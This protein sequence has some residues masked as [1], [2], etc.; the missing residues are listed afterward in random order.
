MHS[1]HVRVCHSLLTYGYREGNAAPALVQHCPGPPGN[2][3]TKG[4][5]VRNGLGIRNLP[6]HIFSAFPL[7]T[8]QLDADSLPY[9]QYGSVRIHTHTHTTHESVTF[10]RKKQSKADSHSLRET[11]S[12][13]ETYGHSLNETACQKRPVKVR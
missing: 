7:S 1:V 11:D 3:L 4:S 13:I 2:Q 6:H 9:T 5:E 12:Q 10:F 8:E